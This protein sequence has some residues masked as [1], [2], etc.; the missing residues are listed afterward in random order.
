MIRATFDTTVLISAFLRPG[1]VSD[2]LLDLASTAEFSLVLSAPIL[3]ETGGKLLT[4]RRIRARYRYPDRDVRRYAEK[5]RDLAELVVDLPPL[6]GVVR[7]P[8]DD[9]VL[10]TALAAGAAYLVSRDKD[11]LDL[12]AYGDVAIL[13]PEEF[14]GLLREQ[15]AAVE[16]S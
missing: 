5:L 4:S 11:L 9:V 16:A 13:T 7:D 14:R 1:G 6:R 10:A 2:E 8:N 15:E 12:G 3:D